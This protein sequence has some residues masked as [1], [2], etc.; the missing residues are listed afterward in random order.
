MV[1]RIICLFFFFF[2]YPATTEIY[3]LSLHDALPIYSPQPGGRCVEVG[4]LY[5]S[6]ARK[7]RTILHGNRAKRLADRLA[8]IGGHSPYLMKRRTARIALEMSANAS[9][10]CGGISAG[11]LAGSPCAAAK[12]H[13]ILCEFCFC[14]YFSFV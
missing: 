14:V 8:G 6:V 5:K 7:T 12:T 2:N 9:A 11:Q 3:T 1:S 4:R 10:G 13:M